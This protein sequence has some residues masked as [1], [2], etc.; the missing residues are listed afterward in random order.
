MA[1]TYAHSPEA[2]TAG[3]LREA[4]KDLPDDAPVYVGIASDPGNFEGCQE[5][6]LVDCEPVELSWPATKSAPERTEV[7]YTLFADWPTGTYDVLD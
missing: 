6:V 4:I 5:R 7:Q 2:W 1:D 3:R